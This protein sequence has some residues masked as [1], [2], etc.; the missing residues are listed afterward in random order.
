M[1][2]PGGFALVVVVTL[3]A[4]LVVLVVSLAALT[5]V[6]SAVVRN[7]AG[8]AGAR[9][10]AL[11]GLQVA[12]GRLQAAAGPDRR[13]TASAA[14]WAGGG[15][16]VAA[17][18]RRWIGVWDSGGTAGGPVD[19]LVS[20]ARPCDPSRAPPPVGAGDHDGMRLV[21]PGSVEASV[22]NGEVV[23]A[24]EQIVAD[25]VPGAA[26]TR[27]IGRF[28]YWVGDEGMKGN[29]GVV[30]RV[31]SIPLPVSPA[32]DDPL[33]SAEERARVRQLLA[34]RSGAD[35]LNYPAS[36]WGFALAA[37]NDAVSAARWEALGRA[38]DE[39]QLRFQSFTD[40]T[41]AARYRA[42]LRREFH[43]LGVDSRGLLVNTM[44]GGLRQNWSDW[45]VAPP[46]MVA[47]DRAREVSRGR[48]AAEAG[49]AAVGSAAVQ[50]KPVVT[51]LAL[52]FVP[53]RDRA[54][55]GASTGRL[56]VGARLRIEL[57]NP[58]LVA[59]AH[60]P[61]GVPDYELRIGGTRTA[62][63]H[64][65]GLPVV[66]VE[67]P[68]QP[69]GLIG[70]LDLAALLPSTRAIAIDCVGDLAAGESC[71]VETIVAEAVDSGLV[72]ADS[73]PLDSSD[74]QLAFRA[75]NDPAREWG[76]ELR[77]AA[78][79]TGEG[80]L[81][82]ARGFPSPLFRRVTAAGWS[83]PG[84]AAF[85]SE[86]G[87]RDGGISFHARLDPARRQW[88]DWV[89]PSSAGL[90]PPEDLFAN[91][92][93]CSGTGWTAVAVDPAGAARA[94][95]AQFDPAELFAAGRVRRVLDLTLQRQLSLGAL[96][97]VAHPGEPALVVGRPWGGTRNEVFDAAFLLPVPRDWR[98]SDRLPNP[99]IEVV[100]SPEA[101]P[102]SAADLRGA[103][104]ARHVAVRGMFNVNSTEPAAWAVAL[105][106]AVPWW[107]DHSGATRLLEN[108]FFALPQ[109]AGF[110][111]AADP[112]RRELSDT[113]LL[114]LATE[115]AGRTVRRGRPF[116]SLAE[117]IASG[118]LDEAIEAAGLNLTVTGTADLGHVPD[119]YTPEFLSTA[120]VLQTHAPFL[121]VRSDTFRIRVGGE[122]VNPATD[123]VEAR[124]YLEAIVQRFPALVDPAGPVD[125]DAT[126]FGRRF[127]VVAFRWLGEAEL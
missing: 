123:R 42:F 37:E 71:V 25:S 23:V 30:D 66:V 77:R 75:E 89:A 126:G 15:G 8:A 38:S 114:R 7:D 90:L 104:P 76:W 83:V 20:G 88:A 119:R 109:S 61:S 41:A 48:V 19:W 45:S 94:L 31:E 50:V 102:V 101:P 2:R 13:V 53:M 60:T 54:A 64:D 18:N 95:A 12:L 81:T 44:V 9:R 97:F 55:D 120:T 78:H 122:A 47:L 29:V 52:D 62:V 96:H 92:L 63:P 4:L 105:G 127:E 26:G 70:S 11:A 35:A 111:P 49:T 107:G 125:A 121:A 82:V 100:A 115:V 67:A 85:A 39:T 112:T 108:P 43:A 28:A 91:T 103:R 84:N 113:N 72:I 98:R 10:H 65:C 80:A 34:H 21:G 16:P 124:A 22:A 118:L 3:L 74:D 87:V 5:R 46:E 14:L 106:R 33:R 86:S 110:A 57:W 69:S 6:E 59:L 27:A 24:R 116:A 93:T 117:W 73:S 79:V 58:Y 99:R 40:P 51:E 1:K 17:E 36:P 68:L 32:V 56:L